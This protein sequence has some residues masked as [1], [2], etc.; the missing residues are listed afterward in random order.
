VSSKNIAAEHTAKQMAEEA[1]DLA[2]QGQLIDAADRMEQAMRIWPPA[3]KKPHAM[4]VQAWRN[5]ISTR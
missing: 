2:K 4:E 1:F 5:G 3:F